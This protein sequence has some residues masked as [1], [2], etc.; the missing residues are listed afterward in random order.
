MIWIKGVRK[1][2]VNKQGTVEALKEINLHVEKGKIFGIIG[3]SG[4]GKSTLVRCINLLEKPT[5]G[6][7]MVNNKE[8]TKLP[9]RELRKSRKKIGMI[10]QHFNLMS[11]RN[12]FQNVAYPLKGNSYTKEEKKQKVLSML[13]LVG[14]SDKILAYPSQLSGGQKQRV[15]IA[16]AL[17]ND[18]QVLLCDEATSAIDPQTTASILKLLKEINEKLGLTIVIITHQMEVVKEIC[19]EVAV[20]EAGQIV[21]SGG[22]IDIFTNPKAEIT[23]EFISTV[24]N[25]DKI[26]DFLCHEEFEE[27]ESVAKISFVGQ[28]TGQAFISKLSRKFKIDASILFGNIEIIQ[29]IPIGNLI[30]KFSGTKEGIVESIKYLEENNINV[31][32]IKHAAVFSKL[33]AKRSGIIS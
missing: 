13:E 8:L 15:A 1:V 19:H 25:Y 22:I 6:Q 4:A 17:A 2:Y 21:E 14:L 26:Y 29:H 10:F 12:V 16:R 32:V 9:E 5:S 33:P 18:P 27:G 7:V 24:F 23:K 11:S 3:Y 20:M 28:K 31:E 30:V